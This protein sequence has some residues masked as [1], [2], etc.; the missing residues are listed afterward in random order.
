[1]Y[2]FIKF[3]CQY[4]SFCD[5]WDPCGYVLYHWSAWWITVG[6]LVVYGS[7]KWKLSDQSEHHLPPS[8]PP[9]P[10]PLYDDI[11]ISPEVNENEAY[12]VTSQC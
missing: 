2:E 10:A 3:I 12:G 5:S 8:S 1:M 9:P 4:N 11:E 7:F 6:A